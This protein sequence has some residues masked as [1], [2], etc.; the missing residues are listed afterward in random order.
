MSAN[1]SRSSEAASL[2]VKRLA[3]ALGVTLAFVFVEALAGIYANSLALLTDAGH[4]FTDVIALAL[5]WHALRLA[6]RPADAGKT[7]GYHR[8]GILIALFNSTTLAL[9]TLWIFYE[10]YRRFIAPP[11][12][13]ADILIVVAILAFIVNVGTALLVRR[14]SS[15]DLNL[16]S[17]YLHLAGDAVSTFGA[18]LA[19]VAIRFTGWVFLD[20]LVSVFIGLLILRNAWG[21]VRESADILLE[22]TPHNLDMNAMVSDL[23][24]V[25]GVRGV[26]DLHVWSIT[27][28]MRALSAHILTD[29]V[30]ISTGAV[31]QRDLNELLNHKYGIA[32][33]ALQLECAGCEP[34]LL[35]CNLEKASH[36]HL[37]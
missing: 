6:A 26:H 18:I 31:I 11:Q 34:D 21:I 14:G 23:K 32:H 20:P 35:Y 27:Q 8:A 1:H 3:L 36:E 19:G 16:K 28:A 9:M 37:A 10:A 29:D 5:S 17:A 15:G 13:E 25:K 24:N 2:T 12:V 33:A 7:F 22:G 30:L 4:N